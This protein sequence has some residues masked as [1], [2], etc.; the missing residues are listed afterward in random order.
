MA[1]RARILS[2]LL[3][4]LT[5]SRSATATVSRHVDL[6]CTL[7]VNEFDAERNPIAAGAEI[8]I[9]V[10]GLWDRRH[11]RYHGEADHTFAMAMH[12]GQAEAARWLAEWLRRKQ[13]GDHAG[14]D[15]VWS[16]LFVG[17][18]RSG[19]SHLA[20]AAVIL[21][22]VMV[23]GSIA[24]AISPTLETGAELDTLFRSLMPRGWYQRREL[25]SGGTS[26]K[27]VNG[28]RISLRSGHKAAGIKAGRV[29]I[30]IINEGQLVSE[31]V[32]T[33][34]RGAVVD[35]SGIV[36][37]T[38]NPPDQ[39]VGRWVEDYFHGVRAGTRPAK[40]FELDPRNNPT[41][42]YSGLAA[43][44]AETDEKTFQRDVL[45]LFTPIGDVVMYAWSATESR[46]D[47]PPGLRDVTADLT[48]RELGR[49]AGYVVGQ[50]YQRS[51]AMVAAVFKFFQDPKDP[52]EVIAWVVDEVAVE[53]ADEDD[54]CDAL[55]VM[56]RWQASGRVADQCYR[57]WIEPTD[58]KDAPV[59][60]AVVAD[61]SGWFQDGDHKTGQASDRRLAARNWRFVYMPQ[62]DSDKN[63]HIL[64]RMKS[65]NARLA[66]AD[67]H[68]RLFVAN[69]C[70]KIATALRLYENKH[71]KPNRQ[72]EHAH[73]VDA[74]TYV[75]YR[76][77]GRPRVKS[78]VG[79]Q[80]A[81]RFKR[82]DLY[83]SE[84]GQK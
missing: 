54:L 25:Q 43:M 31:K 3:A 6:H 26:F 40:A 52:N 24:W 15:Q 69:H 39:P 18:R 42:V 76:F 83:K 14:A 28:S 13:T 22:S 36:L 67:G 2:D 33:N 55:E 7:S 75:T 68:R 32:F 19:K 59:H 65:G 51:P 47:P 4:E 41:I 35:R 50:D 29:D 48:R 79:Y 56:P 63:P 45:G 72:S 16:A 9:E 38:A 27:L 58:P 57:G 81:G 60:C 23:P 17:G 44:A 64:E 70:T 74:V 8:L 53:Q 46:R 80:G 49:A 34:L 71:G 1:S 37:I 84:L 5:A 73:L 62:K 21:H 82:A 77:F 12:R 78:V 66:S 11:K 61:A 30:G 10:G 20:G